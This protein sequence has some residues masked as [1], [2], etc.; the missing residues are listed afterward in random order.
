[1]LAAGALG[2]GSALTT[3]PTAMRAELAELL[4]LPEHVVPM[5]VIPLGRPANALGPPRRNAVEQHVH[6]DRYRG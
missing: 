1:M 3:M 6:R 2:L 4:G 5:A